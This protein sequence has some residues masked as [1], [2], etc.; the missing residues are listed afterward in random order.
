MGAFF[1]GINRNKRSIVLDLKRP[2]ALEALMRLV[3]TADVLVHSLRPGSAERLG[4]AYPAVAA[5]NPRIVYAY[6]PGYRSDGPLRDRPAYDDVIQGESGIASMFRQGG[7]IPR[8]MPMVVADKTCGLLLAGAISMALVCRERT[9]QGQEVQVPMLESLIA[10]NLVEHLMGGSFDPPQ[11]SLGYQRALSPHRRPFATKDGFIC[12]MAVNDGQWS[13]MFQAMGC[14]ELL[15][16]ERF[17]TLAQRTRHIHDL[18]EIVSR[19]MTERT[20]AE[21]RDLLDA[22]DVPNGPMRELDDLMNDPYLA[23]GGF[24]R[25]YE[26][27]SEGPLVTTAIPVRYSRTPGGHHLPPPTLGDHTGAILAELGYSGGEIARIRGEEPGQAP[28]ER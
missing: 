2:A 22:A 20:T 3:E 28:S 4:I 12:L 6:A 7:E 16:E 23:A 13:R 27:P 19:K 10:F 15:A 25:H 17:A 18:Y 21:W 24:F 1:L 26:H 11:G 5:R 14:P 8:Y 9:G